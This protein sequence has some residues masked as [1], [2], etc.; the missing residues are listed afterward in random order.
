MHGSM[1]IALA[2]YRHMFQKKKGIIR[3]SLIIP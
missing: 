2:G 1:V 3:L